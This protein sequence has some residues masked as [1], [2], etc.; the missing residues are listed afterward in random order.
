M[1]KTL[2]ELEAIRNKTLEKINMRRCKEGYR[3]VVG[4]ATCGIAAGAR[5]V[6][7]KIMQEIEKRGLTNVIVAQTGCIGACRLEPIVEIYSPEGN[8]V[9]YVKIDEQKASRIVQEH[10]I[11]GKIVKEYTMTTI[12]GKVIDPKIEQ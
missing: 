4:M 8:K 7:V 9:T 11:K 1:K 10:L 5:P 12:D 3:V 6:M 2:Q